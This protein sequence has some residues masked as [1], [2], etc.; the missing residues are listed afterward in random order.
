V[1]ATGVKDTQKSQASSREN[2]VDDEQVRDVL[3]LFRALAKG[4]L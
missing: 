2:L 3:F 1:R 4:G